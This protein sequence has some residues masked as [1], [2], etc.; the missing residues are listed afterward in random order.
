MKTRKALAALEETL[1]LLGARVRVLTAAEH[2][3]ALARLSHL[4]Q[5]V[6]CALA[7]AVS[8]GAD[9]E[10]LS[11]LAGP[12]YRD[13]TR[14]AASPWGIWRDILATNSREV[15][16]ALDALIDKLSAAREG[17]RGHSRQ[18]CADPEGARRGEGLAAARALFGRARPS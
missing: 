2:D 17:L 9:E 14:L 13:M 1:S 7:A 6:S 10:G 12:G 8:E 16:D 15:A 5:L 4:P 3:R 11:A 18:L